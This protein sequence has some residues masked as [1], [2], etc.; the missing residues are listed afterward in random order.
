MSN[1]P[2][3]S[4]N[5]VRLSDDRLQAVSSRNMY[6]EHGLLALIFPLFGQVCQWLM[7]VSYCTPGSAQAQ[8][9]SATM[10]HSSPAS[11]VSTTLPVVRAMVCHGPRAAAARM[12]SSV[13]RT[14]LFE[15]WPLTVW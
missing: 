12:N 15:F 1:L 10:S 9:D 6:S 3:S 14:E 2:A 8:A 5:L 4:K 13:T 11:S 7:V